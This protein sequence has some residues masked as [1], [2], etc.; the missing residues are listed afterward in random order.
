MKVT[1]RPFDTDDLSAAFELSSA[2]GWN[3]TLR[4]WQRLIEYDP[5]GCFAAVDG[6]QLVGTVTTTRYGTRLAWIGMMLVASTHRRQGIAIRLMERAVSF[7]TAAG[8]ACIR[9]DATPVGRTVYERLKFVADLDLHRWSRG[10]TEP[11]P[12][13][14]PG[15]QQ[16][17][18]LP[19]PLDAQAFGVDRRRWLQRL[20]PDSV[21]S[22]VDGGFGLLRCGRLAS[23]LGPITADSEAAARTIIDRLLSGVDGPVFWDIPKLNQAAERM[24]DELGF[25]PVRD[26]T[27]MTLGGPPPDADLTK[28]F[29]LADPGTG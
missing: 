23:Y 24:A 29:A 3:Q 27:R 16:P 6:D 12:Q 4:D 19:L 9:L 1:I 8:V 5:V 14:T 28:Q 21:V 26:L 15:P 17:Q 11:M 7:L 13:L 25:Q 18:S 10:S 20:V 22:V 2:E